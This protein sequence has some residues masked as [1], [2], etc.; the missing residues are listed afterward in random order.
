[1]SS[2]EIVDEGVELARTAVVDEMLLLFVV[3][4]FTTLVNG[5]VGWVLMEFSV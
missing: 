4:C 3:N 5:V 2:T 1:M